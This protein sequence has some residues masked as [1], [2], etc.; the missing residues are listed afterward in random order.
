MKL[1]HVADLDPGVPVTARDGL[2][3]LKDALTCLA[4]VAL[5]QAGPSV[6]P[7]ELQNQL[8]NVLTANDDR[9]AGSYGENLTV[10]VNRPPNAGGLLEIEFSVGIQCGN[11]NLLLVYASED[12][13]WRRILRWQAPPLKQ[14]SD[15]FGDFFVS[16]V[17]S[18]SGGGT[19][20]LSI[21]VAHG[22]PWCTSR[23]SGFA[24]DV[25]ST[26][27]TP[28]SPKVRWH[29]GRGYSRADFVPSLKCS[30]DTFELRINESSFDIESYERRVIYRYR[31]DGERGVRRIGP[32]AI[33]A[34]GFVEEWLSAPWL[35]SEGFSAQET[36][37][38]LQIVH[39]QF[40]GQPESDREFVT[41]RYGPVRA[42]NTT[43]IF[44]VEIRSTLEKNIPGKPGGEPQALPTRYFHVREGKDGYL[45][46]SAPTEADPDCKSADL[47]PKN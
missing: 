20:A 32:I 6:A 21:V 35:E 8:A 15:A 44:Q 47:M 25:L 5:G 42:C 31:L 1:V 4:D 27:S 13:A 43:G 36:A 29:M 2:E 7:V 23:F 46:I 38:S 22:T 34:R 33:H 37:S 40:D 19:S 39:D 12:A 26:G 11:D 3:R 28:D 24:I 17:L 41:H 14:I 18:P 16:G 9:A 45:M 10:N 30:G